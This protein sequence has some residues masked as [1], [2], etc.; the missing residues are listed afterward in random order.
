MAA[1]APRAE[2]VRGLGLLAAISINVANTIGTGVFLKT[3]VMTCNVGSP[4]LVFTV[5]IAAGILILAGAFSYA[6]VA[7][8]MP[9]AGGQYVFVRRAYGRVVG[10][11]LGWTTFTVSLAGSQA[12]LAVGFAIFLNVALG[13][14]LEADFVR[15]TLAGSPLHL[16]WLTLVALAAIWSV[17]LFNCRPVATGGQAALVLTVLKVLLVLVIGVSALVFATG[18]FSHLTLP[19]AGGSCEGVAASARGGV[20]G[21]GA[22]M[23]G[24]L[25][26]Y[27]GWNNVTPLVGEMR[28]PARNVPRVFFGGTLLVGG[29]Y[30]FVNAA[31]FYVLTPTEIA[32]VPASS[33]VATEVMRRFVGQQ[34]VVMV[35][36]ALMVSSIGALHASMLA[37]SRI[38]FAMAREGLFFRRLADVSPTTH[39]PINAVLAQAGWTSV[40]ALSGSYDVLTD[41]AIFSLWLFYGLSASSIFVFRRTMPDAV[42]PYRAFGYPWLPALFIAVTVFLIANTFVATPRLALAGAAVMVAGLPFY[43][44]WSRAAGRGSTPR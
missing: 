14:A 2:L 6:E 43:A 11:M 28:D 44:W 20:A 39:V 26:A 12:A 3:R 40:L 10:F 4:L 22:A 1:V 23:L 36:V 18:S 27:D 15:L 38:P 5:W 30:L 34:A 31:Y 41:A 21:F 33:S 17:A 19:A 29:L 13:G 32:S 8:M 24:A 9:E 16:S 25:W 37:N 7:S 42:R 35:A